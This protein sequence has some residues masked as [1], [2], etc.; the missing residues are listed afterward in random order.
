MNISLYTSARPLKVRVAKIADGKAE[1]V[2]P[3]NQT[4]TISEKY[5]P[6]ATTAGKEFF[7]NL[8]SHEDLAQSKK[9]IAKEVLK[10]ILE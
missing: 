8:L 6:H 1:L 3:D 7:L 4:V 10:E 9:E 5:L 2:F